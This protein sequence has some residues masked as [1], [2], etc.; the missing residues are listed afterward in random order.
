MTPTGFPAPP[1][2]HLL[3]LTDDGGLHEHAEWT[4]PRPEHGYCLDD[5][6]RALVVV[7]R[8]IEPDR[9]LRALH[10]QY[11]AFVLEAQGDDGR[12]RNRKST[13]GVWHG[14][15]GLEDC[16]GRGIWA[17]GAVV[18]GHAEPQSR[19]ERAPA[20]AALNAFDRAL[21]WRSPHSRA[22]T[23][24][25]L[26]AAE[27]LR[28]RPGHRG[29]RALLKDVAACFDRP[30][31]DPSWPW[32]EPRLTY[33][34]AAVPEAL[35]AAGAALGNN[36]VLA[37]GLRLLGWLLERET[38]DGHLSVTP[39]G[40]SG[41]RDTSEPRF[42]QQPIEVAA[43]SDACARAFAVTGD[44]R[45]AEG[46]RFAA[47]WFLGHND[48]GVPLFDYASGGGCDGLIATG[49]NQNQGAESTIALI[50]A[51]QQ[52]RTLSLCTA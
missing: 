27:V 24:A 12:F 29:A 37:H 9:L 26:G 34:N 51:L 35:I 20:D 40:G 15:L 52:A 28:V 4:R 46:I 8:E 25:G 50:T 21:G 7:S 30:G 42:D 39:V 22:M 10:R 6:T 36:A 44:P 31:A 13:D 23:F 5:V 17:L 38:R 18:S 49:R 45:W 32:P 43:L 3:R 19:F 47:R 41:P 33:A 2:A 16:W 11:L 48:I 14:E 1:F